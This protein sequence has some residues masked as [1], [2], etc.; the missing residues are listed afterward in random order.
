MRVIVGSVRARR[1]QLVAEVQLGGEH[2]AL[3]CCRRLQHL[4]AAREEALHVQRREG[5]AREEAFGIHLQ[6]WVQLHV[7]GSSCCDRPGHGHLLQLLLSLLNLTRQL[8]KWS[9][10]IDACIILIKITNYVV[11]LYFKARWLYMQEKEKSLVLVSDNY[12]KHT[13]VLRF[14]WSFWSSVSCR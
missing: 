9:A 1:R 2:L 6:E 11:F 8:T 7:G 10:T 13:L 14:M 5:A 4:K 12:S 3:L